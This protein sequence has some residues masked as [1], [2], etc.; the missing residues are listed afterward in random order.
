MGQSR[1]FGIFFISN[2]P[3]CWKANDFLARSAFTPPSN[4][5]P[6]RRITSPEYHGKILPDLDMNSPRDAMQPSQQALGVFYG[7]GDD[8]SSDYFC[9]GLCNS[10]SF[11]SSPVMENGMRSVAEA[12]SSCLPIQTASPLDANSKPPSTLS[13]EP[14]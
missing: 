12:L 14:V 7:S 6:T 13:Y 10:G 2:A 1:S 11:D 4:L 5:L 9:L 8:I 3:C